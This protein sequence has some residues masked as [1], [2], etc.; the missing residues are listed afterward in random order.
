MLLIRRNVLKMVVPTTEEEMSNEHASAYLARYIGKTL[1]VQ[2]SDRRMFLGVLK[3]TD[4]DRNL[5]VA[6]A[7]EYREPSRAALKAA[8]VKANG[9]DGK[10]V[11]DMTSRY[12][13]LIVIPGEHI[14]RIEVEEFDPS[15]IA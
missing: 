7:H 15:T 1:R 3:C 11:A 4:K 14:T 13:G 12:V 6:N 2:I 8:A 5:I 10:I 9:S